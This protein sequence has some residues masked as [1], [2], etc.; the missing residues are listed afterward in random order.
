MLASGAL[1]VALHYRPF[2]VVSAG[3]AAALLFAAAA[4]GR[5]ITPLVEVEAS[6]T[7]VHRGDRVTLTLRVDDR[8]RWRAARCRIELPSPFGRIA[9][10]G[11]PSATSE[12]RIEAV[13]RRRGIWPVGP[14]LLTYTDRLGLLGRAAGA[15]EETTVRVWPAVVPLPPL[16]PARSGRLAGSSGVH[17]P[18]GSVTFDRLREYA[19]GDDIRRLHWPSFARTGDLMVRT[20]ADPAATSW[21]VVLDT[22][23]EAYGAEAYGAEVDRNG[24]AEHPAAFEDAVDAVAS[25]VAAFVRHRQPVR[26]HAGERVWPQPGKAAVLDAV[27]DLLTVLEP[28]DAAGDGGPAPARRAVLDGGFGGTAGGLVVVTGAVEIG[29]VVAGDL[30]GRFERVLVL[31]MGAAPRWQPDGQGGWPTDGP[32][33]TTGGVGVLDLADITGLDVAWSRLLLPAGRRDR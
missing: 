6:R 30:A 24:A 23:P 2:I 10:A 7:R 16:L 4:V 13:A 22:R 12:F 15:G 27:L 20:F 19:P 26:L 8:R 33:R 31:R 29:R 14:A 21:T 32:V 9:L 18:G 11:G 3:A 5:R 28:A 1:G 25:I 17:L